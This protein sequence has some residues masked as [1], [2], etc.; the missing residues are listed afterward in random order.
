MKTLGP[1]YVA[2]HDFLADH[3]WPKHGSCT[4]LAPAAFFGAALAAMKAL[5]GDGTPALLR[6]A[7][8]RDVDLTELLHSFGVPAESVRT[9]GC[10]RSK[11][12]RPSWND[13]LARSN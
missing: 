10:G 12:A 9:N 4:G 7:V 13:W 2:D 1:G 11:G 3:E 6:A 5:P 8:G